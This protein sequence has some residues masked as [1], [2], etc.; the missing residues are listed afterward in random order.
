[1]ALPLFVHAGFLSALTGAGTNEVLLQTDLTEADYTA[2]YTALLSANKNPDPL[3]AVGGGDVVVEDG[4]LLSSG[5]IGPEEIT[6]I[7]KGNGE[8]SVY[9]V[10]E[11]D[12]L[13]QIAQMYGVTSNTILWANDLTRAT[14]IHEGQSLVILPVVGVRHTVTSGQTLASIIKKYDANLEEVLEYNKLA[15]AEDITVGEELMIPGG[16]MQA[17]KVSVAKAVPTKTSGKTVGSI[18]LV[19]PVPG[20]IKTQG[21]HGYNGVDLAS[22]LGTP[23]HAAAAGNVIVSKSGGWNGGYGSYIVIKHSNGTQT[24]YGHLSA[25]NVAVGDYVDQNEVIG[26]MGNTGKSTGVHLHFE[27]RGGRNPF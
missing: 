7:G 6:A 9:V 11:G 15:S 26:A 17:P 20:A 12:A 23:I 24:L 19:N 13:S 4:A 16:E 1:M 27:V 14:Q 21:I 25:N 5:P 2:N 10:R 18:G 22:A 3:K 8:I